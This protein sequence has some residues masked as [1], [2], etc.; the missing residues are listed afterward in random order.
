[1]TTSFS[2]VPKFSYVAL[3]GEKVRLRPLGAADATAAHPLFHDDLITATLSAEDAATPQE[4][5]ATYATSAL[6]S[7]LPG[8]PTVYSF[9]IER[10]DT[11][12]FIGSMLVR[13]RPTP[14]QADLGYWVGVPF[15]GNGYATDA[16]RLA[17][18]FAFS[19]LGVVRVAGLA[20][21]TN[22]YSHKVL[23]KNGFN[24]D[25]TLRRQYQKYGQWQDICVF[26]LLRAEWQA[27]QA[28]YAPSSQRV[29]PLVPVLK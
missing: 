21:A 6:P 20:F 23:L 22:T 16:V 8:K 3:T 10:I 29:E 11:R 15:W 12:V 13:L 28:R 4:L 14:F 25:G 2:T 7:Q 18:Q 9:A 19:Q 24:Q 26:T 1:M 5:A 27:Q 17:V